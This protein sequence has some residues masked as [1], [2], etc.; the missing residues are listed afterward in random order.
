[1]LT[2]VSIAQDLL[3]ERKVP[4]DCLLHLQLSYYGESHN[5]PSFHKLYP[6]AIIYM[7]FG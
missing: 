7:D 4:N 3:V 1:M 6:F 2:L 5:Q